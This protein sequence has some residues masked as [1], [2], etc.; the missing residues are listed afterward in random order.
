MYPQFAEFFRNESGAISVDWTVLSAAAVGM[1]IATTAIMNDS[2]SFV[3]GQMDDELRERQLSDEWIQYAAS[4]FEP[5]LQTG[6][7]TSA[8]AEAVFTAAEGQMNYDIMSQLEAGIAEIDA[9]TISAEDLVDLVGVASVAAQRNL[10]DD[11][12]LNHYFGFDGSDP[13]YMDLANPPS[14]SG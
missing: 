1:A 14:A 9:G 12:I 2:L 5:I 7:M 3:S 8:E 10:V 11:A 6:Y 13:A 4:H